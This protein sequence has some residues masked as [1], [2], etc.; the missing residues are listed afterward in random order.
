MLFRS[1]S[2]ISVAAPGVD[3]VAAT[4][5]DAYGY[6]SGTSMATGYVAGLAAI[7]L[8]QS[9]NLN[10]VS[11]RR[12]LEATAQDLGAPKKDPEFG[13]GRIDAAQAYAATQQVGAA[14]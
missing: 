10:P 11:L 14:N 8:A 9:P 3:I 4:P 1:G 13:W 5:G 12:M 2:Y 7:L 6:F